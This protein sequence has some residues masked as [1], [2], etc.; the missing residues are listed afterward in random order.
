MTTVIHGAC[1]YEELLPL[2][3]GWSPHPST[4]SSWNPE[5]LQSTLALTEIA[6]SPQNTWNIADGLWNSNILAGSVPQSY[7]TLE[8]PW[9]IAHQA[10]LSIGFSKNTGVGCQFLLQGLF[11]TQG[12]NPRLLHWQGDSLSLSHQESPNKYSYSLFYRWENWGL[13]RLS[14]VHKVIQLLKNKGRLLL[15]SNFISSFITEFCF[16]F[17]CQ[18]RF[19]YD[20]D[21]NFAL[22]VASFTVTE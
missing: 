19:C 13:K 11:L 1:A 2:P 10:S 3:W 6:T 15:I 8:T 5:P 9:T 4:R 18:I 21:P 12:L 14:D 17:K 16:H 20:F 22:Y 7:L